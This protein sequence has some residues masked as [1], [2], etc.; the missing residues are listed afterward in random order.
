[1]VE[2]EAKGE[3]RGVQICCF[4]SMEDAEVAN[5]EP[6]ARGIVNSDRAWFQISVVFVTRVRKT[7]VSLRLQ[8]FSKF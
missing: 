6:K 2:G 5:L 3:F 8:L 1:M 7:E 4:F